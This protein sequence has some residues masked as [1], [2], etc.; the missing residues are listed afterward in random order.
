MRIDILKTLGIK[1]PFEAAFNAKRDALVSDLE[2]ALFA[3]ESVGIVAEAAP[4]RK[5]IADMKTWRL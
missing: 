2:D 5:I 1:K 4:L 3:V